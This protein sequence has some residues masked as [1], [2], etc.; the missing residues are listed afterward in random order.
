M[1]VIK[2]LTVYFV[3]MSYHV[4][5][6]E[7]TGFEKV[8]DPVVQKRLINIKASFERLSE[9]EIKNYKEYKRKAI[10]ANDNQKYFTAAIAAN[11]ALAIFK[12][13]IDL[14]WLKGICHAQLDSLEDAVD[15]Y[16]KALEIHP[17]HAPSLFNIVEIY[18]Y[19]GKYEK[20]VEYITYIR[21]YLSSSGSKPLP[22]FDFKYL[23]ILTHL[24]KT[25]PT[26]YS[27]DL[28]KMHEAYSYLDDNPFYYYANALKE[29]DLGNNNEGQVWIFKASKI[30]KNPQMIKVWNKVLED[31]NFL[32]KHEI[33]IDLKP[34]KK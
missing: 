17:N 32:A 6:A 1:K 16:E 21:Q 33:F 18:F 12:D 22:L 24:A 8:D 5:L 13:D 4:S 23:V 20:A 25:D 9:D 11:D 2:L 3:L 19:H 14:L 31:S 28:E 26:T 27:K 7:V 30:F 10:E 15:Y 34:N 29:L